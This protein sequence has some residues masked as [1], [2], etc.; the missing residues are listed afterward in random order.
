MAQAV[1]DKI[2]LEGNGLTTQ[3]YY[4]FETNSITISETPKETFQITPSHTMNNQDVSFLFY[5]ERGAR[6]TETLIR[7][8]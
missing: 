6:M 5:P 4:S 3:G 2:R 8:P 1:I 7:K